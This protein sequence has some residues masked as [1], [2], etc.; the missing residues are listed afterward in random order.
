MQHYRK[1]VQHYKKHVQH[2]TKHVQHYRKHLLERC[3]YDQL[4]VYLQVNNLLPEH[5]SAY[6]RFHSTETAMLKVLADAYVAAD[7]GHVTLLSLLDLS[8]ASDTRS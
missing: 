8:A 2:Y 3:A 5:Q 1:H 7:T 6:R 4:R